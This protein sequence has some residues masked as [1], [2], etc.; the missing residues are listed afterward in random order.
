MIDTSGV[1]QW[2]SGRIPTYYSP[3]FPRF[4]ASGIHWAKFL[5]GQ[6]VE[7]LLVSQSD[8]SA[9]HSRIHIPRW[10]FDPLLWLDYSRDYMGTEPIHELMV[11]LFDGYLV[12]ESG[13]IL[14][15]AA[16][17]NAA[18]REIV[19]TG[20]PNPVLYQ[21][22][23][24][25]EDLYL[26]YK[27][28]RYNCFLDPM[29]TFLYGPESLDLWVEKNNLSALLDCYKHAPNRSHV[30]WQDYRVDLLDQARV[31]DSRKERTRLAVE[32]YESL[33]QDHED[34]IKNWP[35]PGQQPEG[36]SG[37]D[38]LVKQPND[39]LSNE[40]LDLIDTVMQHMSD[41]ITSIPEA[42]LEDIYKTS[43]IKRSTQTCSTDESFQQFGRILKLLKQNLPVPSIPERRGSRL[44]PLK[45]ARINTD[46]HIF[47]QWTEDKTDA[48]VEVVV[49]I[50]ASGSM[51]SMFV[52]VLRA[53]KGIFMSTWQA[54]IKAHV[55][56]H[57]AGETTQAT[58][59]HI[60]STGN[61]DVDQR[62]NRAANIRLY[63]NIDGAA[64]LGAAK[65]FSR[66]PSRKVLIHM[67]DGLPS[68]AGYR[69]E[70]AIQH[71]TQVIR[72][73]RRQGI[74]VLSISLTRDVV[75]A[76]N[77]I[78]GKEFNIPA[79]GGDYEGPLKRAILQWT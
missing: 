7:V 60:I 4:V 57:T 12:H 23:N 34:E 56:A 10:L 52:R 40:A 1:Q 58:L 22:I 39:H 79:V 21:C 11:A 54:R 30:V 78:Y 25:V 72:S 76:N 8:G 49:L 14:Y 33:R 6:D 50:D 45:L 66:R 46:G 68:G 59:I 3:D 27:L 47:K 70:S 51:G 19:Y 20:T 63:E 44:M 73:L 67:S 71:T 28:E 15:S 17:K 62:F 36:K 26:E 24:I 31:E 13:H 64:L 53:A 42:K 29:N 43:W 48:E 55:L 61:Y 74:I 32:F 38:A 77:R 41:S 18:L 65:M 9:G 35:S 69:G 2:Y 75:E 16:D 37:F 5:T